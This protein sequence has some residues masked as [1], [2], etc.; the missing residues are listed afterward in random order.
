MD[1]QINGPVEMLKKRSTSSNKMGYRVY[2]G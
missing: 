2:F 1:A